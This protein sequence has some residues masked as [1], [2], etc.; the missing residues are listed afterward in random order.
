MFV[1]SVINLGVL[2]W[3]LKTLAMPTRGISSFQYGS[4]AISIGT[5]VVFAAVWRYVRSA[6]AHVHVHVICICESVCMRE[7]MQFAVLPKIA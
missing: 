7:I 6:V 4:R 1:V 2:F 5:N 3:S